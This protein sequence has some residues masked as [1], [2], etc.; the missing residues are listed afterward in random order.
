MVVITKGAINGF[1][2]K[3]P[4]AAEALTKWYLEVS[5]SDWANFNQMKETYNSVDYYGDD[6]YIFNIMGNHFRLIVRIFFK[7]RTVFIRFFGT[8]SEYDKVDISTL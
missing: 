8:H 7:T 6:L 5:T 3:Y 4:V 1:K 2:E